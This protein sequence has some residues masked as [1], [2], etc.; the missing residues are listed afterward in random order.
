MRSYL[1]NFLR[2]DS[3]VRSSGIT[4]LVVMLSPRKS[5]QSYKI[6]C[7]DSSNQVNCTKT[8]LVDVD[9]FSSSIKKTELGASNRKV[10][11]E[12]V[13]PVTRLPEPTEP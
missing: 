5:D 6:T 12:S 2:S 10:S 3:S 8:E 1:V 13:E 7:C 4:R 9:V 11:L